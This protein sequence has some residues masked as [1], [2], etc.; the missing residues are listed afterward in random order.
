M[1]KQRQCP[2]CGAFGTVAPYDETTFGGRGKFQ[3]KAVAKCLKCGR[4]LLFGLFSG[5]LFGKPSLV[6]PE[7]WRAMEE[8]WNRR[9]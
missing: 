1:A 8:Q 9:T 7:M 5:V 4:G 2:G 3:S 6:P